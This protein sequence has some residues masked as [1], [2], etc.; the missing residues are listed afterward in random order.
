[1]G[2]L[3]LN[4]GNTPAC[5]IEGIGLIRDRKDVDLADN[6]DDIRRHLAA[7]S[8]KIGSVSDQVINNFSR[9]TTFPIKD[10]KRIL[11]DHPDCEFI[12]VYNGIDDSQEYVTYL[13]GIT[14]QLESIATR[15]NGTA[16][17]VC[18]HCKPCLTD[19]LLNDG[20]GSHEGA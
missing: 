18:C 15:A 1:M 7:F 20:T 13:S 2:V 6:L 5:S 10:I 16:S 3:I 9:A 8:V 11:Q 14:P 17:K 12:R 19:G 4:A